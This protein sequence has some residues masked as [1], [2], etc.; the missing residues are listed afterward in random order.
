MKIRRSCWRWFSLH[1][2]G[3]LCSPLDVPQQMLLLGLEPFICSFKKVSL[4][5][6]EYANEWFQAEKKHLLRNI[7][8]RTQHSPSVQRKPAPTTSPD[9]HRRRHRSLEAEL[10]KLRNDHKA[11]KMEVLNLKRQQESTEGRFAAIDKSFTRTADSDS[12]KQRET[13]IFMAKAFVNP[14]FI[15]QFEQFMRM[16]SELSNGGVV[17]KKQRL[18]L[19]PPPPPWIDSSEE[20]EDSACN[21]C[22]NSQSQ[23]E[24]KTPTV[25]TPGSVEVSSGEALD[26]NRENHQ[27]PSLPSVD[28]DEGNSSRHQKTDGVSG[29]E[30]D[31][32]VTA[33]SDIQQYPAV[34]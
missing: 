12:C 17:T 26:F 11:L 6:L 24:Q 20:A 31:P 2:R 3:M 22:K 13:F 33:E 21:D 23:E 1:T 7:K 30:T 29:G 19:P 15:R 10:E 25:A 27:Q 32:V 16:E 18:V 34:H 5:R 9:L 14:E 4:D 8:R 28:D